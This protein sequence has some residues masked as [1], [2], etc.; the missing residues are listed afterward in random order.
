M[1]TTNYKQWLQNLQSFLDF[2]LTPIFPVKNIRDKLFSKEQMKIWTKAFTHE[3]YSPSENYEDLEYAGD[4]VLKWA[5][6]KYLTKRFPHLHKNEFSE[7]NVAYM[8]KIMQAELA[9]KM[10]LGKF[11][12]VKCIEKA[13]L[14]LETDVFESFFGALEAVSDLIFPESGCHRCYDMIVHLFSTVQIDETKGRGCPKTQVIQI[15]VRFDLPKPLEQ[16]PGSK[17]TIKASQ[18]LLPLLQK[19]GVTQDIIGQSISAK[20]KDAKYEAHNQVIKSLLCSNLITIENENVSS[21]NVSEVNFIVRLRNEHIAF[22]NSYGVNVPPIIGN[23]SGSTKKEAEF[24]AYK[25]AF[26]T[27]SQFGI[28]TDWAEKAKHIRDFT[29]PSILPFVET[30]NHKLKSKGFFSMYFF[31]PRKT[32]TSR[33]SVVQL[34][35]VRSNGSHQVLSHTYASDRENGYIKAKLFVIKHFINSR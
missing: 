27:L 4:A 10:D 35:G 2:T 32:T 30:A 14:N 24:E 21:Q 6:P 20:E 34:V 31:I 33:G 3:T 17:V 26:N 11:L 28:T 5:F 22:L 15:F 16:S 29:D 13:S 18:S 12:R 23:A 1:A 19:S 7:L 8:S 9:R 25:Q